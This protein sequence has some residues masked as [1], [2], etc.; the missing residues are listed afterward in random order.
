MNNINLLIYKVKSL[1]K[2][3]RKIL[4]KIADYTNRYVVVYPTCETIADKVSCT[5]NYVSTCTTELVELGLIEKD[6]RD[7]TSCVYRLSSSLMDFWVR[8]ALRKYIPTLMNIILSVGM[9]ITG[10]NAKFV[11]NTIK[12]I[13]SNKNFEE[14]KEF[15]MSDLSPI[16]KRLV[17]KLSLN[18][19]QQEQLSSYPENMVLEAERILAKST[20]IENK[21]GYLFGILRKKMQ[22]PSTSLQ[23]TQ[24]NNYV[25]DN[26]HRSNNTNT[27]SSPIHKPFVP[28]I[29]SPE[30]RKVRML[31]TQAYNKRTQ[32][33]I[34]TTYGQTK[35]EAKRLNAWQS[36]PNLLAAFITE[37]QQ[38]TTE[39]IDIT[40]VS[41]DDDKW[42]AMQSPTDFD[43]IV[44]YY[45]GNY[46]KE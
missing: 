4:T 9:L 25:S 23:K 44:D 7:F 20:E 15:S 2:T 34:A 33:R 17:E 27:Q 11:D 22:N 5:P 38:P 37:P 29:D 6:S 21:P 39:R 46:G 18:A 16:A 10:S 14:K 12:G 31:E 1:S 19:Y 43:E 26:K 42:W 45:E 36:L 41:N 28:V 40:V 32:E 24:H 13:I 3:K 8:V 35:Q 30:S